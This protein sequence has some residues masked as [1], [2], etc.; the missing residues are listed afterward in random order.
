MPRHFAPPRARP[1]AH[2]FTAWGLGLALLGAGQAW[3]QNLI[4]TNGQTEVR[5]GGTFDQIAIQSGG[6]LT[7][8][9]GGDMAVNAQLINAGTF[10]NLGTLA[11]H[12]TFSNSGVFSHQGAAL[13]GSIGN[14]GTV[15]LAPFADSSYGGVISGTGA[16]QKIGTATQT[17]T[18]AQ[19]YTGNT[20]IN[21]G[22]LA[23]SGAGALS[24]DSPLFIATNA[25]LDI[26]G[27][28][29]ERMVGPLRGTSAS[30]V[31]LGDNRLVLRVPGATSASFAGVISGTSGVEKMGDGQQAFTAV[32]AYTGST[33]IAQGTLALDGAGALPANA[34][35]ILGTGATFSIAAADGSRTLGLLRGQGGTLALGANSATFDV[36]TGMGETFGGAITGTGGV[37]KLGG[38]TWNLGGT[39]SYTGAT[40]VHAGT[41]LVA[42]SIA[43]SATTTVQGGAVLGGAGTVGPTTVA[44]GTLAP[45]SVPQLTG[46]I[47]TLT[48]QGALALQPGA[49]LAF[50]LDS[51]ASSDR[52]QV[53]G[54]L[55]L[56]GTLLVLPQAG[57]AAGTYRLIDYTGARSGTLASVAGL[58]AGYTATV[59]Y[60]TPGQVNLV[61]AAPPAPVTEHPI[62]LTATAGGTATCTPNPVPEGATATCTASANA[63]HAFQ[64]WG[65][66]CASA[67]TSS[68]CTLASV[69][70]PRSVSASFGPVVAAAT[71]VP[72]PV[73]G[74]WSLPLLG[75]LLGALAGWRRRAA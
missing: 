25:Q 52:L 33:S 14:T 18:A 31:V 55:A 65:G 42:G 64:G 17:F 20:D 27:A 37:R 16:V 46:P 63:G 2:P 28:D 21:Q 30:Q 10:I 19:T 8:S 61:V 11:S 60:D 58:P 70:A 12:G 26:S 24:A 32:Q 39:S 40:A 53:H 72:I 5:N 9:L 49:Q 66:D 43:A 3:G 69:T 73:L 6:Q 15:V 7:N 44:D 29:G 62:Q 48:V 67:G 59:S 51:P 47:G 71:G 38:G 56:A 13:S 4:V 36:G 54:G 45:G 68:T 41:L 50:D 75:L 34:Y 23:L 22:P 57:F 74:P 1:H 35:V